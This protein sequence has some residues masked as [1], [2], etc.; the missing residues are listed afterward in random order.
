METGARIEETLERVIARATGAGAP[1]LLASALHYAVFP[2]G[3]RIRPQLCLAVA[4][5]C[6]DGD[7]ARGGGRCGRHRASALR[8][9]G[10]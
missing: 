4:Q 3:H 10:A 9:A 7:P 1:P 2:G 8:F 6:G 5:A